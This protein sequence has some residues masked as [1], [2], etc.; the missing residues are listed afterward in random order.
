MSGAGAPPRSFARERMIRD[1]EI[2]EPL[3]A[4]AIVLAM[5]I[6]AR[7]TVNAGR[8]SKDVRVKNCASSPLKTSGRRR[9]SRI[10]LEGGGG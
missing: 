4:L 3:A 9:A 5:S 1:E 2:S 8:S 6:A 7:S 10:D